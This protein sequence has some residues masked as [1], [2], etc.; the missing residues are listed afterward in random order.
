MFTKKAILIPSISHG[1]G[2]STLAK[3]LKRVFNN[4]CIVVCGGDIMRAQAAKSNM[5]MDEFAKHLTTQG[6]NIDLY[7][8][9][10]VSEGIEKGISDGKIVIVD[11]CIANYL[12][13]KLGIKRE[14]RLNIILKCDPM[15]AA[16]RAFAAKSAKSASVRMGD[17]I[18]NT[19]E[20]LAEAFAIRTAAD[21]ARYLAYAQFD[22]L[23]QI[24]DADAYIIDTTEIKPMTTLQIAVSEF[25]RLNKKIVIPVVGPSQVGKDTTVHYVSNQIGAE[26]IDTGIFYRLSHQVRGENGINSD[27]TPE[28]LMAIE[29]ELS[30]TSF[31]YNTVAERFLLTHPQYDSFELYNLLQSSSISATVS[32]T[33]SIESVRTIVGIVQIRAVYN[34]LKG[35][36]FVFVVGRDPY[37]IFPG[38]T[39]VWFYNSDPEEVAIRALLSRGVT[40]TEDAINQKMAENSER[41]LADTNRA[42]GSFGQ[43]DDMLSFNSK[44]Y[45]IDQQ[46]IAFVNFLKQNY[47]VV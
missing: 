35:C 44:G 17:Q 39:T 4:D 15:T 42:H 29:N 1:A 41:N 31:E 16:R 23:G 21:Q 19:P 24:N 18:C 6:T 34:S 38:F 22:M 40:L 33:S 46:R 14:D 9:A 37:K 36:N 26:T 13:D 43:T 11:S 3:N 28:Q 8:D 7:V 20:E 25:F 27:I 47:I 2:G 12:C 10:K 32:I 5:S 30:K 45:N